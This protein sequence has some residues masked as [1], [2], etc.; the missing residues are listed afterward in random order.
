MY[1]LVIVLAF[2]C[3]LLFFCLGGLTGKANYDDNNDAVPPFSLNARLSTL[4]DGS[5][6]AHL[7]LVG[8]KVPL[9]Y[10]ANWR[11]KEQLK[12]LVS[13]KHIFGAPNRL[14]RRDSPLVFTPATDLPTFAA[15]HDV[16]GE[17]VRSLLFT[18]RSRWGDVVM[19]TWFLEV[20]GFPEV[21]KEV[22]F[23]LVPSNSTSMTKM[24]SCANSSETSLPKTSSWKYFGIPRK[25][26]GQHGGAGQANKLIG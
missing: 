11:Y 3:G 26:V 16:E 21:K 10:E 20:D 18:E 4:M 8:S 23:I 13:L 1:R 7:E 25:L 2:Q 19:G 15:S 5:P 9:I 6:V 24:R 14:S 22:F 17:D 12:P